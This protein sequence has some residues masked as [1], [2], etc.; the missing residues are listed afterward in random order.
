MIRIV[1]AAALV[2]SATAMNAALAAAP[3]SDAASFPAAESGAGS[4]SKVGSR[5]QWIAEADSDDI[6]GGWGQRHR[7][8]HWDDDDDDDGDEESSADR[9]GG[10]NRPADPNASNA[11]V[12]DS[13]IFNNHAR[14]K[15][16]VQ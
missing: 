7:H 8:H 1:I 15:V 4:E 12:P 3:Q 16:E 14:P 5:D 10:A 6:R 9:G 2:V 11:P 13:G